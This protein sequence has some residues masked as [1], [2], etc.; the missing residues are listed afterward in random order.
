MPMMKFGSSFV[1]GTALSLLR[2]P[3]TTAR[4]AGVVLLQRP[5]E[6]ITGNIP[7]KRE[8]RYAPEEA[9]GTD[10]FEALLDGKRIPAPVHGKITWLVDGKR[11]FPE[12]ERRIASARSSVDVQA[13]I[14]DNDDVAVGIADLLKKRSQ[15][16]PVR[17]V[18]DDLGSSVASA[19][20]PETPFPAGFT[21]PARMNFHLESGSNVKVRSMLNPWLVCDHTKLH[22]FDGKVALMGC[23][24]IGREYSSEWHDL[25]FRVEG[26]AVAE[27]QKD[28]NKTWR[29]ASPLGIFDFS[30][31]TTPPPVPAVAGQVPLRVLRTD[32]AVG[33]YEIYKATL[34]GIRAARKRI[35]IEDPYISND[36]ITEALEDAAR[37]GVDVRVIYPG[38]ND[39]KIMDAAN[40]TFADNLVKA[41]GKAYAYP[42]MSHLKV[43]L[44]DDWACVGSAN[45]DTLSMRINRELNLSFNAK[46]PV[47]AL[48][49]EVFAPDFARSTAHVVST[50]ARNPIA[51]AVADQL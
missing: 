22:V 11:F 9:P 46:E 37:R 6:L 16:V 26:N 33:R 39:S 15:E 18:F 49:R 48:I 45:L 25:M 2:D 19:K 3:G 38:K 40:R 28:F 43:I 47:N 24:N 12:F 1:R 51:E 17:V 36:D 27:L 7:G 20:K 32:P 13:Y 4:V 30:K 14:F 35:W 23:M 8:V 31:K 10:R 29:R 34:L 42:R 21:P 41:G 50:K 44:C 5:R